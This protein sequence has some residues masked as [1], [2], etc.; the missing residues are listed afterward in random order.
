MGIENQVINH[1][2]KKELRTTAPRLTI[3]YEEN[4]ITFD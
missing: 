2:N 1:V 3:K 4:R